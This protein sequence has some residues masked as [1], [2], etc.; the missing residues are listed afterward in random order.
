MTGSACDL[1]KQDKD[2]KYASMEQG[3]YWNYAR[4]LAPRGSQFLTALALTP[5]GTSGTGAQPSSSP[6]PDPVTLQ[7]AGVVDE[8]D[9]VS[10]FGGYV[11]VPRG[12]AGTVRFEYSLPNK[13]IHDETYTLKLRAQAGVSAPRVTVRVQVPEGRVVKGA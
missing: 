4:V 5:D 12:A 8:G 13:L 9:A 7:D 11:I 3:C 1:L 2:E 6:L 10:A